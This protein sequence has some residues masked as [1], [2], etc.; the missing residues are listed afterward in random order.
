MDNTMLVLEFM[1]NT[2]P[3][4]KIRIIRF[5][6]CDCLLAKNTKQNIYLFETLS[7]N[8]LIFKDALEFESL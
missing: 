8:G 3:A 1:K 2:Y 7:S 6:N 4:I 5:Q